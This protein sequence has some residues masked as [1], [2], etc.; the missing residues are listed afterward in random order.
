[1]VLLPLSD[2]LQPIAPLLET[3]AGGLGNLPLGDGSVSLLQTG[4]FM[5]GISG[6]TTRFQWYELQS[7]PS[8]VL[9]LLKRIKSTI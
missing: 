4:P 7:C 5:G 2:V 8:Q 3:G 9:E 6:W 1:M